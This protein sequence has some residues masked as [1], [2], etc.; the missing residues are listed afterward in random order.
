MVE[1][2]SPEQY[3]IPNSRLPILLTLKPLRDLKA[4]EQTVSEDLHVLVSSLQKDPVL[5]H[6][7]VVDK[8]T[9]LV[10]DGTHRLAALAETGCQFAPCALID[11]N[12]SRIILER[13]FRVIEGVEL[14]E[15]LSRIPNIDWKT[16]TPREAQELLLLRE[17]Y[18]ALQDNKLCVVFPKLEKDP[19]SLVSRAFE[20]ER[21]ARQ[22]GLKIVF[23]DENEIPTNERGFV[24]SSIKME[25]PEVLLHAMNKSP[26]PPKTT[27]HIIPSRPLGVNVPTEWLKSGTLEVA[28]QSFVKHL[29]TKRV[30]R[31]AE[32][33][34]VGSRRYQEELFLFE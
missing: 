28:R 19:G 13:W 32:G 24:L 12:D 11:Y 3:K 1:N 2:S 21:K 4:H 26:F 18:A 33:S 17:C 22:N 34:W 31:L 29:R 6:P 25:K 16:S 8:T 20:I 9:G 14:R 30:T 23:S 15:Y 5:R 7:I 27:R 10:L